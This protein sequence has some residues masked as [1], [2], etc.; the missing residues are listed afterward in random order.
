MVSKDRPL[1]IDNATAAWGADMP[2][3]VRELAEYCDRK[4]SQ[5]AAAEAI[6]YSVAVV[7]NVLR[8]QYGG[9]MAKVEIAVRGGIMRETV[10]CPVLGDITKNVCLK[11]Q[12]LPFAI[13]NSQ[14]IRIYRAC[15]SECPHSRIKGGSDVE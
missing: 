7:C 1:S 13:T 10:S 3:W 2:E 8:R 6:G 9:D 5:R 12:A 14:R 4:G 11:N 15:R